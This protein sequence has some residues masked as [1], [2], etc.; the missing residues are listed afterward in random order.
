MSRLL[1]TLP[2]PPP[3]FQKS[4]KWVICPPR[5]ISPFLGKLPL[6]PPTPSTLHL[7][8]E[9]QVVWVSQVRPTLHQGPLAPLTP[10]EPHWLGQRKFS[11]YSPPLSTLQSYFTRSEFPLLRRSRRA[12][13]PTRRAPG[14]LH[15]ERS[16]LS[17]L[18]LRVRA[19][20]LS[21]WSSQLL[22]APKF[23]G[24]RITP[25]ARN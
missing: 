5:P 24:P 16:P 15:R 1:P 14:R 9:V 10:S 4:A 13:F 20:A 6:P 7:P 11:P 17:A 21:L 19:L 18:V 8:A 2:P 25:A 23:H 3:P 12:I 22:E